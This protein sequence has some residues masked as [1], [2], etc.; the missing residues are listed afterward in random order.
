MVKE[1]NLR[2]KIVEEDYPLLY[3]FLVSETNQMRR[4]RKLYTL[5]ENALRTLPQGEG[6]A[7]K[8]NTRNIPIIPQHDPTQPETSTVTESDRPKRGSFADSFQFDE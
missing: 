4:T 6:I 7:V 3:Q 1:L 5:A 2:L 8:I